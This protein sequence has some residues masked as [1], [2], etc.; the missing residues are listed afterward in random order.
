MEGLAHGGSFS[1]EVHF[2]FFFLGP[3]FFGVLIE[4]C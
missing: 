3:F 4:L 1:H 2:I